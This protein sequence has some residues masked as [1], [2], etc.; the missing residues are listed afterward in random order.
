M[1][2]HTDRQLLGFPVAV[3]DLAGEHWAGYN[4]K[5]RVVGNT[6]G[7]EATAKISRQASAVTQTSSQQF[8]SCGEHL[9]TQEIARHVGAAALELADSHKI[10]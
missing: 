8:S 5:S 3:V 10:R 1:N 9:K 4:L 2:A 6:T 7:Q